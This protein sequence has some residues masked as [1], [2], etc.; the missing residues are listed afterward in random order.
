MEISVF[1]GEDKPLMD[2]NFK[3]LPL[4]PEV[5]EFTDYFYF[6]YP[7]DVRKE[8]D[9]AIERLFN[10]IKTHGLKLEGVKPEVRHSFFCKN[11]YVFNSDSRR[12]YSLY[13]KRGF[14]IIA[15]ILSLKYPR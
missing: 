15:Q 9:L 13:I 3:T 1:E 11:P 10:S 5:L 12:R 6:R 2:V 14:I 4:D 8:I 7:Q